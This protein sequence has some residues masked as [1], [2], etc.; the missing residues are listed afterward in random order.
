[1]SNTPD[2]NKPIPLIVSLDTPEKRR[3]HNTENK[4]KW[5][6]RKQAEIAA[7]WEQTPECTPQ[8]YRHN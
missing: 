8:Q 7:V 1:M 6:E 4:R 2:D 5:R 3:A